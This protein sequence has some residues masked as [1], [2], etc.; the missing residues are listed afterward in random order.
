[1][2]SLSR[3]LLSPVLAA[4]VLSGNCFVCTLAVPTALAAE[5][6]SEPA[7]ERC[8][9]SSAAAEAAPSAPAASIQPDAPT[10]RSAR[11]P[12]P[13]CPMRERADSIG[14]AGSAGNI[15]RTEGFFLTGL[16]PVITGFQSA[17]PFQDNI[18]LAGPT[19]LTDRSPVLTGTTVKN[20]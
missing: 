1:M 10:W 2:V 6:H 4:I 17:P 7:V 19:G 18:Y 20:E 15:S 16:P 8:D 9:D 14:M 13:E 11:A 12:L 3:S 5:H